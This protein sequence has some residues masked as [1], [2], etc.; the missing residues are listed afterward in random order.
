MLGY[1]LLSLE[2]KDETT[3]LNK[4]LYFNLSANKATTL[5]SQGYP[6]RCSLP[7]VLKII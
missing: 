3:Q 4:V 7:K 6:L 5:V 1:D 2:W